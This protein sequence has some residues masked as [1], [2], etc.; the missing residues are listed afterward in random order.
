[1]SDR[2]TDLR[3][4]NKRLKSQVQDLENKILSVVGKITIESSGGSNVSTPLNDQIIELIN[5]TTDQ[6]NI[7]TPKVDKFYSIEM[8]KMAKK[9]IPILLITKDRRLWLQSYQGFYDEIKA[10]AGINVINNP[11][12]HFLL[13]FNSNLAIYSGGALDKGELDKSILIVTKI[14]ESAKLRVISEIFSS[15][16]PSFMRR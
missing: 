16:L 15:M 10:T 11:N 6:L 2:L 12:V 8:I 1:M 13:L 4:E 5:L 7:V 14:K 3:I 9:G